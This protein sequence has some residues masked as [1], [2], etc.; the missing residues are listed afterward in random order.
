MIIINLENN[1]HY[2]SFFDLSYFI[3]FHSNSC[4]KKGMGWDKAEI[5]QRD[6][7][8]KSTIKQLSYFNL[9]IVEVNFDHEDILTAFEQLNL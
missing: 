5:K 3:I 7:E 4:N 8:I 1:K 6:L 9:S 2:L